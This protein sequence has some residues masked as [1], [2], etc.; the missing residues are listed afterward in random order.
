MIAGVDSTIQEFELEKSS[1]PSQ[2][3]LP[4]L[5]KSVY[6]TVQNFGSRGGKEGETL[7][8]ERAVLASNFEV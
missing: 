1:T 8:G 4:D 6:H 3:T 2:S 5:F 7:V